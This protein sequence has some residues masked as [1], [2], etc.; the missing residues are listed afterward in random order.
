MGLA[1]RLYSAGAFG[2]RI[3]AAKDSHSCAAS[4]SA[5]A[6]PST[7]Y[8]ILIGYAFQTLDS[9][10]GLP[11]WGPSCALPSFNAT[12]PPTSLPLR[13]IQITGSY[14]A[15]HLWAARS[16]SPFTDNHRSLRAALCIRS[17]QRVAEGLSLIHISEPTRR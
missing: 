16:G 8:C 3:F 9:W 17:A 15:Q 6:S 2:W 4:L 5:T 12:R 11:V 14:L 1:T 7:A 13:L 10:G